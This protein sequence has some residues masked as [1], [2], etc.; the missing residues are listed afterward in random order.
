MKEW[1]IIK[2]LKKAEAKGEMV[3]RSFRLP[4]EL[5]DYVSRQDDPP[6]FVRELIRQ[7][8]SVELTEAEDHIRASIENF[9][10]FEKKTWGIRFFGKELYPPLEKI[11]EEELTKLLNAVLNDWIMINNAAVGS[12]A[13]SEALSLAEKCKSDR[14]LWKKVYVKIRA[15]YVRRFEKAMREEEKEKEKER[16]RL[17]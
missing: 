17:L 6:E 3:V 1:K 13:E 7:H 12:I 11:A 2:R 16:K 10:Y 14:E 15:D 9:Y 8:M 5:D 4:K